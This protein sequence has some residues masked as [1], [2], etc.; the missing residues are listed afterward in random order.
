[1]A[2]HDNLGP[3]YYGRWWDIIDT[4]FP[5]YF[6]DLD[7]DEDQ[8]RVQSQQQQAGQSFPPETNRRDETHPAQNPG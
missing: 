6:D 1:M 3:E 5:G 8:Q 4:E 7:R 2:A